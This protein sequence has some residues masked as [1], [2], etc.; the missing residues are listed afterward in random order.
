MAR[1]KIDII[2]EMNSKSLNKNYCLEF[3]NSDGS[4]IRRRAR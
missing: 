1:S 2:G 3:T 4:N